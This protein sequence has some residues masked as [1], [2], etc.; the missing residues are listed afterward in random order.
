[1]STPLVSMLCH[2]GPVRALSTDVAGRILVWF[3]MSNLVLAYMSSIM[4]FHNTIQRCTHTY[5]IHTYT[6]TH[7]HTLTR[8]HTHTHTHR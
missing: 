8:V 1:M 2:H 6:L 5:T 3:D 4:L 7:T